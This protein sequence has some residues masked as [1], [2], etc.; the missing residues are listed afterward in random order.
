MDRLAR[1]LPGNVTAVPQLSPPELS[2]LL[3]KS[4][5]LV[6]PSRSEGTPRVIME[7]F[8]RGRPVIGSTGGGIPDLVQ[9]GR[10]GLLVDPDDIEGLAAALVLMLTDRELAESSPPA[11]PRTAL[12]FRQWTPDRYADAL[13]ALVDRVLEPPVSGTP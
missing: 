6:L 8:A 12:Y 4:T 3:D 11:R 9:A 5:A 7:A 10:N 13:R 1:D 2:R